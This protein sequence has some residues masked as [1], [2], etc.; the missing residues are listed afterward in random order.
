M[1]PD[2]P[3]EDL[4]RDVSISHQ[5][6]FGTLTHMAGAGWI[7]LERWRAAHQPKLKPGRCGQLNHAA[8]GDLKRWQEVVDR[9]ARYISDLDEER[10]TAGWISNCSAAIPVQCGWSIRCS[11]SAITRPCIEAVG[12]NDPPA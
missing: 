8:S 6:I 3:D 11:M 2:L 5:S 4:R 1:P 12:G 9:R 7:W 10:L